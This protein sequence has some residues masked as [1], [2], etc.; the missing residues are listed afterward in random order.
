MNIKTTGI[1]VL[2][3]VTLLIQPLAIGQASANEFVSN[4]ELVVS[5][6]TDG[7]SSEMHI[8]IS[9]E[10]NESITFLSWGTPFESELLADV[11]ELSTT[12]KGWPLE[13]RASYIGYQVKR[14]EP[15]ASAYIT[16]EPGNTLTRKIDLE[17]SYA[18]AQ[19]GSYQ[20]KYKQDLLLTESALS[21][22]TN[23][24]QRGVLQKVARHKVASVTA[25]TSV[26]LRPG[27]LN[28]PRFVQPEYSGCSAL[29][30][31]NI[32]SVMGTSESLV[33]DV[34]Q[35]LSG[36]S[37]DDLNASPRYR[38]WFGAYSVAR[39]N[40][41]M[42]TFSNMVDAFDDEQMTFDCRCLRDN[43]DVLFGYIRRDRPWIVNLCPLYF[44]REEEQ[45]T[46][47][48]HELTHFNEIGPIDDHVY[49]TGPSQLLA[50]NQPDLAV[51]NADNYGYFIANNV[52]PLQ[53]D[54]VEGQMQDPEE[55]EPGTTPVDTLFEFEEL[56]AGQSV[57]GELEES[58]ANF[59]VISGAT[60]FELETLEGDADLYIFADSALENQVCSSELTTAIDFCV[61]DTPRTLFVVV[62]G[63]EASRYTFSTTGFETDNNLISLVAGEAVTGSLVEGD[64]SYYVVSNVESITLESLTGDADLY[65]FDSEDLSA[66][67]LICE[68][69]LFTSE[70]PRD[71]CRVPENVRVYIR[72]YGFEDSEFT[73]VASD[74]ESLQE[75]ESQIT[76]LLAGETFSGSVATEE[77]SV[78]AVD[79]G[80]RLDLV[81][82][83]G[84][85]DLFVFLVP[86]F[87]DPVCVSEEFSADSSL[88]S[89]DMVEGSYGVAVY[90]Y[91]AANFTLTFESDDDEPFNDEVPVTVTT[92]PMQTTAGS[93]DGSGSSGGSGGGGG[94]AG[95]LLLALMLVLRLL[96]VPARNGIRLCQ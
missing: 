79:G 33:D 85:A 15:D 10:S 68:S 88:D 57:S 45:V 95:R 76:T 9:N 53:L 93:I 59:F 30:Q 51:D 13:N 77:F 72:V 36:F 62:S 70:S 84:D 58:F 48:I 1:L 89:C 40:T 18:V 63:Y 55:V 75:D 16:L 21:S 4:S 27:V 7:I 67:S 29:Q 86:D 49:G 26:T 28:T 32:E 12:T 74:G 65:V 56:A 91:A 17:Q 82:Q 73:L 5:V 47:I 6:Q 44:D 23:S 50:T 78:F 71:N 3:G 8:S 81:S 43:R 35:R 80:G 64:S 24:R 11:F 14:G 87:E 19:S 38:T 34:Y 60:E 25:A 92:N 96:R 41:V 46:T 61:V 52:P 39:H 69:F 66:D 2:L 94:S 90:G 20:V 54:P 37:P 83:S 31:S 22:T 42:S